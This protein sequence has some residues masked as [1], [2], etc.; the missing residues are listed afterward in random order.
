MCVDHL[1]VVVSACM[2]ATPSLPHSR[3]QHGYVLLFLAATEQHS[4]CEQI[5]ML[6]SNSSTWAIPRTVTRLLHNTNGAVVN[7]A[8]GTIISNDDGVNAATATQALKGSTAHLVKE[9]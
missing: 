8:H 6:V 2:R 5:G 3:L 9:H 4:N 1:C 7:N